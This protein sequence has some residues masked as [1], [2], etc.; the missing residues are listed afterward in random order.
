MAATTGYAVLGDLNRD[1][2]V[3]LVDFFLFADNFGLSGPPEPVSGV[4]Q[5]GFDNS[6]EIADWLL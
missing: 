6:D 1:G 3:D 4:V 2:K 5:F